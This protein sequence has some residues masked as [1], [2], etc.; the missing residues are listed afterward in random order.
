MAE[1]RKNMKVFRTEDF[2]LRF[3]LIKDKT[4]FYVHG[5]YVNGEVFSEIKMYTHIRLK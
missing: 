1:F 4:L 3:I 2:R 5:A